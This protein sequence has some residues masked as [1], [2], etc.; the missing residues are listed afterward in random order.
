[1]Q[2]N[3][4]EMNHQHCIEERKQPRPVSFM[5]LSLSWRIRRCVAKVAVIGDKSKTCQSI[6]FCSECQGGNI[7][8]LTWPSRRHV[9]EHSDHTEQ[10]QGCTNVQTYHQSTGFRH[11]ALDYQAVV[12]VTPL[13]TRCKRI[14]C[15]NT[16]LQVSLDDTTHLILLMYNVLGIKAVQLLNQGT[17]YFHEHKMK[18]TTS[19]LGVYLYNF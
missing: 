3:H 7:R 6:I 19:L 10:S 2:T 9:P 15:C 8:L 14:D 17:K 12:T 5:R 11:C 1:M 13:P 18:S 4:N 16:V